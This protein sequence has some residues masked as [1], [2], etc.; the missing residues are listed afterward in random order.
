[1]RIHVMKTEG[2]DNSS[3]H[4][5]TSSVNKFISTDYYDRLAEQKRSVVMQILSDLNIEYKHQDS[6][7][8]RDDERT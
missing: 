3:N 4:S 7:K 2:R 1:M 5:E 8:A 6:E